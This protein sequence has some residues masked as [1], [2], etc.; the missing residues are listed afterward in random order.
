MSTTQRNMPAKHTFSQLHYRM[1]C[2]SLLAL[3]PR[4]ACSA[5]RNSRTASCPRR[6]AV[7]SYRTPYRPMGSCTTRLRTIILLFTSL[8]ALNAIAA[9]PGKENPEAKAA[10]QKFMAGPSVFIQNDGQWADSS[11]RFALDSSGANVGLTDHGPR[12]QLFRQRGCGIPAADKKT[13]TTPSE[14]M[15]TVPSDASPRAEADLSSRSRE[16]HSFGMVFDGAAQVSPTGR[17]KSQRTFNYLMG[18]VSTHRENV[19]S[20]ESIWYEDL[21]PGIDL[22]LTG[23]RTGIKYNFHV[24]P[25]ADPR[26]IRLRYEGIQGLSL[27]QDGAL[28]IHLAD[29]WDSLTDTAPYIYQEI[30][31]QKKTIAGRFVLLDVHTYGFELTGTYD[32]ILP[33]VIDPQV[34]WGTYIGGSL[35]EEGLGI[36]VDASGN[37]YVVGTTTS[38]TGWASGGWN[39]VYGGNTDAFLVKLNSSGQ[40]VW[41][42]YLGGSG[43]DEAFAVA[44]DGSGNAYVTGKTSTAGWVSGGWNTIFGGGTFDAFLVKLDTSGAH[45]WSTYLG[46]ATGNDYG[47]GVVVDGSENVCVTGYTKSAGWVSLGWDTSFGGNGD[48]FVVEL[49]ASGDHVWSSYLGGTADDYGQGICVDGSGNVYITGYTNSSSWVAGGWDTIRAERDGFVV[50]LTESGNHIWSSY[51]GGSW[52]DWAYSVAVDGS[53]S[54]YI[55]GTTNSIGWVSGGWKSNYGGNVDGFLVKLTA[56]GGHIWSTYLGSGGTEEGRGVIVDE[57]N[58]TYITGW[59]SSS[60]WLSG[61]WD[62]TV[63]H[64]NN[65]GF[66]IKLNELGNHLWSTYFGGKGYELVY[67]IALD[68]DKNL[69]VT[70]LTES[71]NWMSSGGDMSHDGQRDAF[72]LKINNTSAGTGNLILQLTPVEAVTAG[73]Q[74]RR[75]YTNTWHNSGETETDIPTG[76]YVIEFKNIAGWAEPSIQ[77]VNIVAGTTVTD[78]SIYTL[79]NSSINWSSYI[80]TNT[81]TSYTVALDTNGNVYVG[82]ETRLSSWANGGWDITNSGSDGYIVKFNSA[83]DHIW[84]TYIGGSNNESSSGLALDNSGNVYVCGE[85]SSSSSWVSGGWNTIYGGGTYD[86]FIVKLT[87]TGQHVW[88]SY[89]GGNN[90]DQSKSVA[91]DNT[92]NLFISGNT[93]SVDWIS[94]GWKTIYGGGAFD[95]FLVKLTSS[96]QYLW[97]TYLGGT[98]D[99]NGKGVAVDSDGNVYTTGTTCSSGWVSGGWDTIYNGRDSFLVKFTSEGI[100]IWSTYIG[101]YDIDDAYAVATDVSGN[102]YIVG[103]TSSKDWISGGGDTTY[104][105]GNWDGFV[106]KVTPSGGH[107]W[108]SYLGGAQDDVARAIAVNNN[109]VYVV[110]STDSMDWIE[111][112]SDVSYNGCEDTFLA[113]LSTSGIIGWSTYMGGTAR[114]EGFGVAVDKSTDTAYVVGYTYSSGWVSG[115]WN[116]TFGSYGTSGF[117]VKIVQSWPSIP[118]S[119]AIGLDTIT[120]LWQDNSDDEI[121][122]KLWV[123]VGEGPPVTLAYTTSADVTSWQQSGLASNTQ[124]AFQVS[125]TFTSSNSGKTPNYSAWTAIEPVNDLTFSG[126]T[127]Y[128]VNV[129]STNTPNNLSE[130]SSGLC[131][132]N[133][134]LGID[135]GWWTNNTPC[136]LTGLNPNTEYTFRGISRN[137]AGVQ[138]V[139]TIA[140]KYTLAAVPLDPIVLHPAEHPASA[141]ALDVIITGGDDNPPTTIYA[142]QLAPNVN[143]NMWVQANGTVGS[144]P[145]YLTGRMWAMKRVMGLNKATAYTFT[146]HAKNNDGIV[147]PPGPG[148][149]VTTLD[150]LPPSAPV[151][152]IPALQ[153][154]NANLLCTISNPSIDPDGDQ[155]LYEFD[156]YVKHQGA[157]GFSLFRDGV[158]ETAI[159]SQVN[160][161]DTIVN[162]VWYCVVIPH[163]GAE[164]G[165][166]VTTGQCT[167]V[168]GGVIPSYISEAVSPASITLGQSVTALGQ[169]FPTPMGSGTISFH[170]VSP[171]GTGSDLFPEGTVFASGTYSKTFYPS[172]ASEGRTPWTLTA[173]WPG[174]ATYQAATSSSMTFTVLKAQPS[175]SVSLS[176]SAIGVGESVTAT[177]TLSAFL[178]D[179]LKP[180]LASL[181]I[182]LYLRQPDGTPAGPVSGTT[183]SNGVATFAPSAFTAAGCHLRSRGRG[184]SWRSLRR[185]IISFGPPRRIMTRRKRRAS[186]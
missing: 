74:W 7:A 65:D 128:S 139:P 159:S 30:N 86:G 174:D 87:P 150:N 75:L 73:A 146:V 23:Q 22:E 165:A 80:G 143:G 129:N 147:T 98:N 141:Y 101:G 97:S 81:D 170:S 70:G 55:T 94:N 51:I 121:A 3:F 42:S 173:S 134:T 19:P 76:E 157:L 113:T 9:D 88:S 59:T 140:A 176:A 183:N 13:G 40:H 20:Y 2:A 122:F 77:S 151:L 110:G 118:G 114:D 91:L 156:W 25:G 96:G 18:D 102:T 21:Y 149:T 158:P 155:I 109:M 26:K 89:L 83:G 171:S 152:S 78:T 67:S 164:N 11:I 53:G 15:G 45:L 28:E 166:P 167:I 90:E 5:K 27:R 108:S 16:M 56:A 172:E 54:V 127:P 163:D 145:A 123:N 41:S 153:S 99:D 95:G 104:G 133:V 168:Q 103:Y 105:G 62:T 132:S 57:G 117:V 93:S 31:G 68:V 32:S 124:Y 66:L 63:G 116:T 130:G 92:G 69:Y 179:T 72:A 107:E 34:A 4:G 64:G 180:L 138:T 24:A 46:G 60:Y 182:A 17:G 148:T 1:D 142:I 136:T 47:Y 44:V 12:F 38:P 137:G 58:N 14:K 29:N 8:L 6:K 37:V 184:S 161:T 154:D 131:F 79:P 82:G 125:A 10:V 36:A 169:I 71:S 120:W 35:N 61:G 177:S 119:T 160:N 39:T 126:V 85:T 185:T 52:N 135:S 84:S 186:P 33:I 48:A 50:K 162:D 112:G 181:P 49:T 100:H 178:P 175:L 43:D 115:G 106:V 144:S 111:G